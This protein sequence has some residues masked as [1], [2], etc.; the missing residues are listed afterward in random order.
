MIVAIVVEMLQL[1]NNEEYQIDVC[2]Y[3]YVQMAHF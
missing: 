2:L 1:Q 3:D